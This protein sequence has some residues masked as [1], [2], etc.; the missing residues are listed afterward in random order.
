MNASDFGR[1]EVRVR[2]TISLKPE[3]L[4]PRAREAA[5][6]T[7]GKLY[8]TGKELLK[9]PVRNLIIISFKPSPRLFRLAGIGFKHL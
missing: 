4:T 9:R 2:G 5:T 3:P 7:A 1:S 8:G 6:E